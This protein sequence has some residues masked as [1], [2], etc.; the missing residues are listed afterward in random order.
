MKKQVIV[1]FDF[2]G[3]L[4]RHDTFIA[5]IRF[6]CGDV[7]F[8]LGLLWNMPFLLAYKCRLYPNW[9]AKQRL[10]SY[11]F[12]GMPLA[13][14]NALCEDFCQSK[15]QALFRSDAERCIKEHLRKGCQTVIVS[16]SIDNWVQPFARNLGVEYVIG[17]QVELT[18]DKRLTGCFATPNCYGWEKVRRLQRLFPDKNNYYLIAYGD[19]RGDYELLSYADESY[20]KFFKE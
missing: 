7:R 19:S 9:K 11:F 4:T 18:S 1:A 20:Y 5:F 15:M 3:T 14:F 10:F 8:L 16:A 17:T 2:D 6:A 13:E 12:K